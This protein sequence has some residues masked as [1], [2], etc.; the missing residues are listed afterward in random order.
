M[1]IYYDLKPSEK[2]A[3]ELRKHLKKAGFNVVVICKVMYGLPEFY[4]ECS[5]SNLS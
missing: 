5:F 4:N 1:R 2:K 3:V